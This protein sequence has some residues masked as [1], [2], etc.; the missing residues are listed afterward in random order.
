M[1]T[2][3]QEIE[4]LAKLVAG[5]YDCPYLNEALRIVEAQFK[6]DITSDFITVVSI[7]DSVDARLAAQTDLQHV[8]AKLRAAKVE[9]A[10]L[11]AQITTAQ[12]QREEAR[13]TLRQLGQRLQ[14]V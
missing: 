1:K 10:T 7:R 4:T 6:Q 9:L 2:K 13:N 14:H 5:T 11:K 12:I 8:A 3:A